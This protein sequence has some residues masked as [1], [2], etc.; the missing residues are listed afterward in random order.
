MQIR[1]GRDGLYR[2]LMDPRA[3]RP[4]R[5]QKIQRR[6]CIASRMLSSSVVSPRQTLRE[7]ARDQPEL[8]PAHQLVIQRMR[9]LTRARHNAQR[10]CT[11]VLFIFEA[12]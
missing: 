6:A 11:S 7:M 5:H 10:V 12:F 8:N 2:G 3:L 4:R 9:L 1:N